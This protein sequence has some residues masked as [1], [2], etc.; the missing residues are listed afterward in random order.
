MQFS[1]FNLVCIEQPLSTFLV[2]AQLVSHTTTINAFNFNLHS[3]VAYPLHSHPPICTSR[4]A[5]T[6]SQPES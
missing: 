3:F 4:Q 2:P 5:I 6:V 1:W